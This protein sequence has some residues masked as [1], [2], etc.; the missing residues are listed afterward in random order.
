MNIKTFLDFRN[1]IV[2]RRKKY[3]ER[4]SVILL[5]I[6]P[7][8]QSSLSNKTSGVFNLLF[9]NQINVFSKYCNSKERVD[10]MKA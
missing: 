10:D 2:F 5:R 6:D 7:S 8:L 9:I 1:V 3:N 4:P